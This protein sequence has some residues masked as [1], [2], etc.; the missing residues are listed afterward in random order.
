MLQVVKFLDLNPCNI[1]SIYAQLLAHIFRI[2]PVELG[3][4]T[5]IFAESIRIHLKPTLVKLTP[6]LE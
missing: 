6:V 5:I 4:N 2:L 1:P 3:I